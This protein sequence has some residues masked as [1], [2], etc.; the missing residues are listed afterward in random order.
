MSWRRHR[1]RNRKLPRVLRRL[2][3]QKDEN[4]IALMVLTAQR[5]IAEKSNRDQSPQRKIR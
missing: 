1:V 5:R 4:P 3:S 2:A